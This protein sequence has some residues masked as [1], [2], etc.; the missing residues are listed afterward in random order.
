MIQPITVFTVICD[1]CQ[2]DHNKGNEVCGYNNSSF[3][4]DC[5]TDD[6]WKE[7]EGK[8]YCP[9]CYFYD[10]NSDQFSPKKQL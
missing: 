7:I 3:A 8:H 1:R 4:E 10:D 9:E 6:D 2:K 5:A